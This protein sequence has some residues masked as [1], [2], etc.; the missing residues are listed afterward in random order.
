MRRTTRPTHPELRKASR[1][2]VRPVRPA[3]RLEQ[4]SRPR[5]DVP[6]IAVI[7]LVAGILSIVAGLWLALPALAKHN[8]SSFSGNAVLWTSDPDAS[9][10]LTATVVDQGRAFSDD[11]VGYLAFTIGWGEGRSYSPP[12]PGVRWLLA[13]DGD[14]RLTDATTWGPGDDVEPTAPSAVG[15]YNGSEAQWF[16]G[17]GSDWVEI[18][19]KPGSP[20]VVATDDRTTVRMPRL[21]GD[22]LVAV[23]FPNPR[24]DL[25][26]PG[27]WYVPT[28]A[29]NTADASV[30]V[31]SNLSLTSVIPDDAL[32]S[33]TSLV[34]GSDSSITASATLVDQGALDERAVRGFV[35]GIL[36]GVGLPFVMEGGIRMSEWISAR[37]RTPGRRK[38]RRPRRAR[39]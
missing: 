16:T 9:P 22:F 20:M 33:D 37:T 2:R 7:L 29:W 26:V 19:G 10:W 34:W 27:S 14:A 30:A 12:G 3:V 38:S 25:P 32:I 35:G 5:A 39:A 4:R 13:L 23:G 36:L 21:G 6:S 8:S 15:D 31:T 11:Q 1:S 24:P 17:D 18:R 28:F